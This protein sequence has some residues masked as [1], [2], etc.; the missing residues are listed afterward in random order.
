[1]TAEGVTLGFE[2]FDTESRYDFLTVNG[3]D[4]SGSTIPTS[5]GLDEII[6]TGDRLITWSSDGSVAQTG[7]KFCAEVRATPPPSPPG[8]ILFSITGSGCAK[9]TVGSNSNCVASLGFLAGA[10]YGAND[11]CEIALLNGATLDTQCENC[12]FS[13]EAGYDF[14]TLQGVPGENGDQQYSGNSFG[15]EIDGLSPSKVIWAADASLQASGWQFCVEAGSTPGT[16]DPTLTP[17]K[18]PTPDPTTSAPTKQAT[19]APSPNPTN[20]PTTSAPTKEPT[21]APSA[22]PTN[23]PTTSAPTTAPTK[24]PTPAKNPAPTSVPTQ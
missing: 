2:A 21:P 11:N 14:I 22:N 6:P 5:N 18:E 7:W 16:S 8:T 19:P 4:Y 1:V 15:S 13:T 9:S 17:T 20:D 12:G 24:E 23:D 3:N 10:D